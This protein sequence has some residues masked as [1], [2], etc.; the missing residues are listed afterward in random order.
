MARHPKPGELLLVSFAADTRRWCG[1]VATSLRGIEGQRA[2]LERRLEVMAGY[3]VE[4]GV[5]AA[6]VTGPAPEAP[7]ARQT[8][9][10]SST[11]RGAA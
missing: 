8:H 2:T 10:M 7:E 1:M 9:A 3:A 4:S 11:A 5:T 6:P